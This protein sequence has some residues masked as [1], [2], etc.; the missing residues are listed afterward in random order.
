M[1]NVKWHLVILF[2]LCAFLLTNH[3]LYIIQT[4]Q[5]PEMDEQHYMEMSTQFYRLLQHPTSTTIIDIIRVIP[6]R[7]PGY[8]LFITPFLLLLGLEHS[9]R[10]ALLINGLFYS[11]SMIGVYYL[12]REYFHKILS[13]VAVIIFMSFGWTLFYL[14]FT[15]SETAT[16]CFVILSLLF[17]KKS[18]YF[19]N[20][21]Y[22]ILFGLIFSLGLLTRWAT[23]IFVGGPCILTFAQGLYQKDYR[24]QTIKNIIIILIAFILPIS[25]VYIINAHTFFGEYVK[26]QLFGGQI[27]NTVPA[28]RKNHISLQSAAYYFKVFEQLNIFF[29]ILFITGGTLAIFD[30]KK[31]Y[32]FLIIAFI[33]PYF[34]FSFA[35][36]IKDDRYIVPLYPVIAIL[37]IT[38]F[39]KIGNKF[40]KNIFILFFILIAIGSFFGGLWG[41]GPMNKGLKSVT[42][43]IPFTHPRYIHFSSMVWPPTKNSTNAE[44]IF[45]TIQNIKQKNLQIILLFSYHP[46]D[47]A[48]Y[49]TN[50]YERKQPFLFTNFVGMSTINAGTGKYVFDQLNNAD[51]I[52]TKNNNI[53]DS[54]FPKDNYFVL[55]K[56]LNAWQAVFT[57]PN[58]QF[59][60]LKTIFVPLDK[61][62]LNIYKKNSPL[63]KDQEELFTTAFN[64]K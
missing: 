57:K 15:Y 53:I 2:L 34:L 38:T 52:I 7:Q 6:F 39:T 58:E 28:S 30:K 14:H 45:Q 23:L 56:T 59:K 27:W 46:I 21:K 25:S 31:K 5:Y 42:V 51:Y 60:L 50:R 33:V 19:Q 62:T 9:Y 32:F 35:T 49:A 40:C 18:N 47:I 12:A 11:G 55:E 10:I 43:K 48:I 1:K 26:D 4:H 16:T 22:A 24:S 44:T 64:K 3:F 37:S 61:S 8:S 41:I 13:L 20:T 63:S 29:F 17:L 36:I 54:Y